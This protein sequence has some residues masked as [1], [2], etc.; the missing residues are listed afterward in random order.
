M[1]EYIIIEKRIYEGFSPI[2]WKI[3]PEPNGYCYFKRD[4][5]WIPLAFFKQETKRG[6]TLFTHLFNGRHTELF[7]DRQDFMRKEIDK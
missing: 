6:W 4:S 1:K 7:F 5:K 2:E 3:N